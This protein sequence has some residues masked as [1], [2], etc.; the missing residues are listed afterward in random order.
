[1]KSFEELVAEAESWTFEGWDFS[2][3][4]GRLIESPT[5]W[6]YRTIVSEQ[7]AAADSLVDL[8]T[9]GGELLASF[10]PLPRHT[11][12]TEGYPPNVSV[13][14]QRLQPLGVEVIETYCDGNNMLPQRGALPFRNGSI[15]LV[16]DRHESFIPGEVS[17]ILR[18]SGRFVTQQVGGTNYPE[19]NAALGV[20]ESPTWA[21]W[22]LR[23]AIRQVEGAGF[24]VTD[25]RQATLEAWF[26]DVGV[27]VCYLKAVPWQ[28]PG[29]SVNRYHK[30]L[31]DLDRAIRNNGPFRVTFPRFLV[32]AVKPSN[33]LP[34]HQD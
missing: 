14:K 12:A 26:S 30:N 18:P 27:V 32:Q 20:E 31:Q 7:L 8:G 6:D 29:F 11:F 34:L 28:V 23:E 1:L 17:R 21:E 5:P 33:A 4:K 2:H 25:S 10:R 15:D 13:A 3:L 22:D 16:I 19:L 24:K 9:G